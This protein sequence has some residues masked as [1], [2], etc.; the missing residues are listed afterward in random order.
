MGDHRATDDTGADGACTDADTGPPP[1]VA[2]IRRLRQASNRAIAARDVEQVVACMLSDVTVA[3]AHGPVLSGVEA[4]RAAFAEQFAD[5]S[6][7]GYV[8]DAQ[9]VVI[10]DPPVR[11]TER[12]LWTGRWRRG[13]RE[14]VMRGRYHA[15]WCS[16]PMGWRIASEQFFPGSM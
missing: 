8:R 11:A 2:A 10:H 3:V 1:L 16:T 6:F 7:S 9:Q 14:D 12:G 15:E 13:P 5:A 4:S